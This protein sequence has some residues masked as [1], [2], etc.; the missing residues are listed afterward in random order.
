M[1][2]PNPNGRRVIIVDVSHLCM[3]MAFSQHKLSINKYIEGIGVQT[4][5]TTI[6]NG[7]V[8]NIHKWSHHGYFP[9]VVCFDSAGCN[10][11]RKYYFANKASKYGE[12]EPT[13][14]KSKR[15]TQ[16]ESYFTE[17]NR[18]RSVL[19]D[20]GVTV[21]ENHKYEADDLVFA[22]IRAAKAQFPDLPI[23]VVTSDL[24]LAPLV[25]EQVSV[26]LRSPKLDYAESEDIAKKHYQ[27]LTPK[28]YQRF[29]EGRSSIG[30]LQVP[31]NTLLLSKLLRGDKSDAIPAYPKFTPKK[32]NK[33]I[34][35]LIK[36]DVDIANL[37]R[38]DAPSETI[39][40]RGTQNVVP[41]SEY[42]KLTNDDIDIYYSDSK[43]LIE[44]TNV[45]SKYLD[46]SVIQHIQY[47]YNGIN[48]NTAF[49][50]APLDYVRK[51]A[52]IAN[53]GNG[54]DSAKLKQQLQMFEINIPL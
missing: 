39:C 33:L 49:V 38:Y 29:L 36:D 53:I 32:Y 43:K 2:T 21:F 16:S 25:D 15:G 45:L 48:L 42:S 37:F 22:A 30:N 26:F 28:T 10:R 7:V 13:E 18:T 23:D 4:I 14:Y 50:D 54:Y 34:E 8:K 1:F 24:D 17:V 19:A 35:D 3:A 41:T 5:D 20:S 11:A 31:Y 46:D 47:V 44:I 40:Y 51:P 27:Q 9:T 6:M 52:Y 12:S